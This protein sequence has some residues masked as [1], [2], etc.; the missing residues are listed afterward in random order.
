MKH[1]IQLG[2]F[3]ISMLAVA[4]AFVWREP[5][6]LAQRPLDFNRDVRPILSDNCFTCHGP[7]E[8][9]RKARLRLDT[10]DLA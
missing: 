6:A 3:A 2:V 4:T 7:D 10:K 5:A 9:T 8:K 1:K